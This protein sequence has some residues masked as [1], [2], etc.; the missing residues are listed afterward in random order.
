MNTSW[1]IANTQFEL[2]RYPPNQHDKS[3][4][5]WDSSDE[6]VVQHVLNTYQH[7]LPAP[8]VLVYDDLFGAIS[9]GL[10]NFPVSCVVDSYV[11]KMAIEYNHTQNSISK[12]PINNALD[13]APKASVVIIKLTK[14]LAYL[15]HQLQTINQYQDNCDIIATGKT[16]L[17][18]SSVMKLFERYFDDVSSSLAKKKSRLIFAHNRS[19]TTSSKT[20]LSIP[21]FEAHWPEQDLVLRSFANVFSKDQIDIGGR[22]LADHLPQLTHQQNNFT[23]IDLG[24]GNGLLGLSYLKQNKEHIEDV[25]FKM[26]FAD[27]SHMAIKSVE[28]NVR[29]N[30]SELF[31]QCDFVQDDCLS[32]QPDSS[33]DLI[34][35]N[36][37]F[38]QQNTI[39]THI[40]EQMIKQSSLV[41]KKNGILMLVANKHLPYQKMLKDTFDDFTVVSS[42]SKFII[43]MCQ[44]KT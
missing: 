12:P 16:T 10:N 18:T 11:S 13:T 42:N 41:L 19:I 40:T 37:P 7:A 31:R 38:H 5:A 4:Q 36:P 24:C 1:T 44:N 2:H 26:I 30:A 21:L 43:Y 22:F 6:L 32:Q 25:V 20:D 27:E 35:C 8:E 29:V 34:L 39:T 33:A 23:V 3:L 14:N 28:H 15:E 9:L 17:V